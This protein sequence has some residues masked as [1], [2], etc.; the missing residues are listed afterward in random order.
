[1]NR[2]TCLTHKYM[3]CGCPACQGRRPC[4]PCPVRGTMWSGIP[5]GANHDTCTARHGTAW[6]GMVQKGAAQ[7]AVGA[8]KHVHENAN[9]DAAVAAGASGGQGGCAR[10]GRAGRPCVRAG[11]R[12][13]GRTGRWSDIACECLHIRACIHT[14]I[15]IIRLLHNGCGAWKTQLQNTRGRAGDR[16]C[17]LRA[18]RWCPLRHPC[19]VDRRHP[20][21]AE[22]LG[23]QLRR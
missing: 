17:L 2:S 13:G 11:G 22:Q 18:C 16:A 20:P 5:A 12:A 7:H 14:T 4:H 15:W 10:L 9:A 21:A 23:Q 8:H 1:M 3:A 19:L 6:H